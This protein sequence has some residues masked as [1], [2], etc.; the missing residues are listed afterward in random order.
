[1]PW[2]EGAAHHSGSG[3]WR[4]VPINSRVRTAT[5]T[6]VWAQGSQPPP[7]HRGQRPSG[8]RRSGRTRGPIVGG[9]PHLSLARV[10]AASSRDSGTSGTPQPI[11]SERAATTATQDWRWLTPRSSAS[12]RVASRRSWRMR[13]GMSGCSKRRSSTT[14]CPPSPRPGAAPP[15]S[16][17]CRTSPVAGWL[18]RPGRAPRG[19]PLSAAARGGCGAA[20]SRAPSPGP[21]R[22]PL[23]RAGRWPSPRPPSS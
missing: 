12:K 2:N 22:R 15:R 1:M 11:T 20:P 19:A 16:P 4:G 10:S 5:R 8:S 6:S 17:W 7:Q 14:T 23:P 9:Q 21:P 13:S 18:A 3:A